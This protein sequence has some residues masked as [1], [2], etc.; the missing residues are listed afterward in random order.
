MTLKNEALPKGWRE[1]KL[2]EVANLRNGKYRPSD[3]QPVRC[4]E[5]EHLEKNSGRNYRRDRC[6]NAK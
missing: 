5:L 4:I 2:K 3:S 6:Q 1:V